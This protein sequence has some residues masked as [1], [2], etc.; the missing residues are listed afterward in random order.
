MT[1]PRPLAVADRTAAKM[2][3]MPLARFRQYVEQGALPKPCR[4]GGDERWRVADLDAI[5]SG[6]AALPN[7]DFSM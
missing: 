4:I 1:A 2:L 7:E 3:D 5:L 6:T